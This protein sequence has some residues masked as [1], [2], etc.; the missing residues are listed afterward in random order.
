VLIVPTYNE[1]SV[2][3]AA[4]ADVPRHLVERIIVADGNSTDSTVL[5][6]A[7]GRC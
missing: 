3:E 7:G 4:L 6:G 2:I 1:E 5:S